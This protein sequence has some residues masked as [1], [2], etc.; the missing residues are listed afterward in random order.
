LIQSDWGSSFENLLFQPT[1]EPVC[2]GQVAQILPDI[3]KLNWFASNSPI[4]SY[5][6]GIGLCQ[7]GHKLPH[8]EL[9]KTENDHTTALSEAKWH[10]DH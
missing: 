9:S 10:L 8:A 2:Y 3:Q 5:V 7:N 1:Q 6:G 4:A